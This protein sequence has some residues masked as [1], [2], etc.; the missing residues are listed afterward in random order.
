MERWQQWEYCYAVLRVAITAA[1]LAF[2]VRKKTEMCA[3]CPVQR[4]QPQFL[5]ITVVYRSYC[6]AHPIQPCIETS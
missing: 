6:G 5:D 1:L 2:L 4:R 3:Q